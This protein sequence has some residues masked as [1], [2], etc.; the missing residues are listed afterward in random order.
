[1][2]RTD[3]L[4]YPLNPA[5]IATRPAEPRDS[6]K[7]M[8]V[9]RADPIPP[10]HAIFKDLPSFLAPGDLL[11]VNRT[12]VLPARIRARREDT[13]GKVEGL[14]LDSPEPNTWRCMLKSNGKLREGQRLILADAPPI[15]AEITARE[16]D[17]WRLR[18]DADTT[19]PQS[20]LA[21][22]GATPLPPYI[23]A[24]RRASETEFDDALDQQWYQCVY[25]DRGAS[26]AAP[27]AGL[28]FTQSLLDQLREMGVRTAEVILD[29]GAGTFK[30]VETHLVADHPIHTERYFVPAETLQAIASTRQQGGRVVAVGTTT[31]RA[32]ESAALQ[33]PDLLDPAAKIGEGAGGS[34]SLMILPGFPFRA[35]DALIT[36]FHQ[37]RSTLLALVAALVPEGV[38][39]IKQLYA[40]ATDA[41]YRFF[42]YGDAMLFLP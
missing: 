9:S 23:S 41:D 8:V 35:I 3:D 24:A 12:R 42:S 6:A 16:P 29:V 21:R 7:L 10:T 36:N 22:I 26:V 15:T 18:I 5:R 30:P 31:C 33:V 14:F 34:T 27:T 4:D 32:L 2:L 39:Q 25:A 20:I 13:G 28:H 1:M 38:P 19:D 40:L 17:A 37:P 11:V